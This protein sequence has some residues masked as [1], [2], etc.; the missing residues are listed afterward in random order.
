M[1]TIV[2]RFFFEVWSERNATTHG[3]T[4]DTRQAALRRKSTRE[5]HHTGLTAETN[6]YIQIA[7][8]YTQI[9]IW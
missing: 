3:N 1:I 2:W 7:A 4:K 6:F 5:I 9:Q 8:T